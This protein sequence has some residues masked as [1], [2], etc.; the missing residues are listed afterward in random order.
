M[1][2]T[3]KS[4]KEYTATL[5]GVVAIV[6]ITAITHYG[7]KFGER[8]VISFVDPKLPQGIVHESV[9]RDNLNGNLVIE[10]VLR[11]AELELKKIVDGGR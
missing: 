3:K 4:G 7:K 5:S 11:V 8:A 10:N 6:K 2:W 9:R 1:T